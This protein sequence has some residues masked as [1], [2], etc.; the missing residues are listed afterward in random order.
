MRFHTPFLAI[1]IIMC[2]ALPS[3][4]GIGHTSVTP[5]QPSFLQQANYGIKTL[6]TSYIART[7]LW[8]KTGWWN[9]ANAVTVLAEYDQLSNTS[10]YLS[11]INNTF[12]KN[13]SGGFLD[14]Y[15]DDEGW[16]ALAWIEAYNETKETKYLSA[17]QQ[18]FLNMTTGWDQT[19]GGGIWWTKKKRVKNTIA[20][21]LFLTVAADLAEHVGGSQEAAYV[22]WAQR[23]WAWLSQSRIMGSDGLF[24]GKLNASCQY[25]PG[26]KWTYNQGVI[27]GGLVALSK[28]SGNRA[29]LQQAQ[30]TALTAISH[31]A[32]AKDILHDP[33]EP[34]CGKDGAEFKGIFVRNL[35]ILNAVDP[36]KKYSTFLHAN[37]E[38]IWKNDRGSNYQFGDVWS[39]RFSVSNGSAQIS[40]IDCFLAAE[41]TSAWQ[42]MG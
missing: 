33:C 16:W 25:I 5:S 6:Q 24:H 11:V 1:A 40:A 38:S 42:A 9:A 30:K 18:I 36:D 3:C 32:D 31:M 26:A 41:K 27:V 14:N 15:Y 34:D 28:V 23:E 13:S 19:C 10:K 21:E 20:N 7:G 39:G 37:A 4:G 17:A 8:R 35:A 12:S 22:S 2:G 29:L